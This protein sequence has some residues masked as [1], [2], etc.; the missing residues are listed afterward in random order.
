M[1]VLIIN[2]PNLNLLGTREPGIYGEQTFEQVLA[3][4]RLT[5]DPITI[6][7]F[8]SNHE[9]ELIDRLHQADNQGYSGIILNAG[10][11]SHTSVALADAV[12]AIGTPVVGVHI[13]NIYQRESERHQELMSQYLKGGIFGLGLQGYK[14]A[15]T[16]I[17]SA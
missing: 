12:A 16:Y 3:D 15:I 14:L 8:Q 17:L 1:S 9:G 7:Y 13:S 2:G 6:D 4:L 11:Y 5:Y 10:G